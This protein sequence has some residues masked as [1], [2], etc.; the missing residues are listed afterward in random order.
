MSNAMSTAN[1]SP[2]LESSEENP[3]SLRLKRP[4]AR[5]EVLRMKA[6]T[7]GEQPQGLDLV[8]LNTNE[9]PYP[10][11]PR[12]LEALRGLGEKNLRCYP[13]PVAAALRAEIAQDLHVEPE[14]VLVGN[15]S[16]ELLKLAMLGYVDR[17]ENVGYLWPT[18]SLYPV[19]VE[20]IGAWE[21][22][23]R[24]MEEGKTQEEALLGA[25]QDDQ[26]FF[27]TN[28]NP[29]I[30]KSTQLSYIREFALQRPGTLV[31][32]DEAYIAYGGETALPLVHEGIQNVVVSRTFSKSHSLAGMRVGFLVGHPQ[33][34]DVLYRIKDSYNVNVA[35]QVAAL[36]SWKDHEY[37]ASVI[38]KVVKTRERIRQELIRRGFAVEE[39]H[40]NFVFARRPDAEQVF[41]QLRQNNVFVRYFKTPELE[42][43]IRITVGTDGEMNRMLE[44]MD[45]FSTTK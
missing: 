10:P 45:H 35:S 21:R 20:Q 38:A 4:L 5:A 12:V 15:G 33:I 9:N 44:V 2:V 27:I 29:P 11:S 32:V 41:L 6:Y 14:Q 19:F 7:P 42:N 34:I 24:W 17:E 43:G 36:A 30:G 40:G 26:L 31:V 28:P 3:L 18:Y 23:I 37:T 8:K 25:P 39:S 22:P 1:N 13:Q 16:D